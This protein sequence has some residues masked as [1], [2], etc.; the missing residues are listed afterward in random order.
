ME[1]FSNVDFSKF[2][3]SFMAWFLWLVEIDFDDFT[4]RGPGSAGRFW[5]GLA[6]DVSF[7]PGWGELFPFLPLLVEKFQK[8]LVGKGGEVDI[9]IEAGHLFP[10]SH[11]FV[12]TIKGEGEFFVEFGPVFEGMD[13][14]PDIPKH[15]AKVIFGM[16]AFEEK[17]VMANGVI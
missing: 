16:I 5:A 14:G 6:L 15:V 8:L 10:L 7:C 2:F 4:F 1:G 17:S 3:L 13:C 9:V 11:C 12:S